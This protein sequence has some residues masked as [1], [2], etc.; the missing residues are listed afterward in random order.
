MAD[1]GDRF[2]L[3]KELLDEPHRLLIGAQMIGIGDATGKDE[4]VVI[5]RRHL[6]HLPVDGEGVGAIEVLKRLDGSPAGGDQFRSAAGRRHRLPR[7][8][9]FYLFGSLGRGQERDPLSLQSIRHDGFP[10]TDGHF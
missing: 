9:Q 8:G 1:R 6:G 4:G 10:H 7:S 5:G 3:G 2:P